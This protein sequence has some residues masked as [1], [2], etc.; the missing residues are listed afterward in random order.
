MTKISWPRFLVLSAGL[1]ALLFTW[2]M[3]S[4][5]SGMQGVGLFVFWLAHVGFA[6]V[7]LQ[8]AQLLL[9]R[10]PRAAAWPPLVQVIISGVIGAI[11]FAPVAGVLDYLSGVA[12]KTDDLDETWLGL[13]LGE[14]S[15][16]IGPVVLVWIGLNAPHL[17][18]ISNQRTDPSPAAE[19]D[20]WTGVPKELGRDIIALSAELHYL[21]VYTV[22]GNALVLAPFGAAVEQMSDGV[23]IHRSH[24]VALAHIASMERRGQGGI[25]TLSSGLELPVSRSRWKELRTILT[26]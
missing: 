9:G 5:S 11:V 25:C 15:G 26:V 7:L 23:Q 1:I 10:S 2:L 14:M 22:K 21:R 8:S 19:P 4:S 12:A 24:W 20:F 3:P 13:V 16:S 18:E 17:V 6:L